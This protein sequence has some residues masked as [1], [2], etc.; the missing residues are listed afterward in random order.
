[1]SCTF[2]TLLSFRSLF[3]FQQRTNE[4]EE[5]LEK[6][7]KAGE[8]GIQHLASVSSRIDRLKN[9]LNPM[10]ETLDP[11]KTKLE[12]K[13]VK[14]KWKIVVIYVLESKLV[15]EKEENSGDSLSLF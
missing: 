1:M 3:L 9:D 15:E 6:L 8:S 2:I 13:L 5:I 4:L 10:L 7:E 14:K 12:S 11:L